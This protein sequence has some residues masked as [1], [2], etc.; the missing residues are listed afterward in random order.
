MSKICTSTKKTLI[1]HFYRIRVNR[2]IYF[3]IPPGKID[4]IAFPLF[5][6][7]FPD[8]ELLL[9]DDPL[10]EVVESPAWLVLDEFDVPVVELLLLLP[11]VGVVCVVAGVEED[12]DVDELLLVVVVGV[13]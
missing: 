1:R 7:V 8:D 13:G 2:D 3:T 12:S 4:P 6:D 10:V 5:D 11:V 9:P